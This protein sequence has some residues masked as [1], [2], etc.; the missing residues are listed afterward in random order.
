MDKPKATPKDFF[1]W[2][3]AML[4]LYSGVVAFLALTFDYIN[5][6]FPDTALSNYY[7]DP[8]SGSISYEMAS[9][10]VLAPLF[11]ILMRAIRRGIA[12]DPSRN[13]V[14][15]RRWALF[16][17]LFVAGATIAVDL[18]VLLTTFLQGGD[19]TPRFLLKVALV[20]LV[21]SA[22]FMHF[23]ADV[24][25]YW[26]KNPHYA[27][28]INWAVGALVVLTVATGFLVIGSPQTQRAYRIDEQRV[29]DLGQIQN[30]IVYSYYQPKQKL[31]AS[32]D[33]LNDPISGFVLPTDPDTGMA[34]E[35]RV[36]GPLSFELCATF[37]RESRE[38]GMNNTIAR[39]TMPY[40]VEGKQISNNWDHG[41]GHTCFARTID[42]QLY[43]AP[44][45]L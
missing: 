19:M 1:L 25:G 8:Y 21:A 14:W 26:T 39:P 23:I 40:G 20:L 28:Y 33:A 18:I 7:G 15:V 44:K 31:P 6:A 11:L 34:Y 42:P 22:G 4:A 2:A 13:E 41:P 27:R 32:L 9:L 30:Q 3:G 43:P 5:Y 10:I 12:A 16:L 37:V 24:W 17:T 45:G 36:T 35:Y 38:Q 29:S